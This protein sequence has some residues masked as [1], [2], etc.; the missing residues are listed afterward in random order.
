MSIL[1]DSILDEDKMREDTT[2]YTHIVPL[3]G[4]Q[5]IPWHDHGLDII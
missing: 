1:D 3:P 4:T 5:R 2:D